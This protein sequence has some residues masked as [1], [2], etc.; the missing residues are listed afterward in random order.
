MRRIGVTQRVVA[1]PGR[2]ERRDALDQ[3]WCD[4]LAACDA[5]AVPIPNRTADAASFVDGL[6]LDGVLLSGGNDVA[7][8]PG[9]SEVAPER[10]ALESELIEL[11]A[12]RALPL[13]GVCHGLQ[14][15]VV[16]YGGRL[17]RVAGHVGEPHGLTERPGVFPVALPERVNSFHDF[18]VLEGDVGESLRVGAV[19]G[20]GLVEAVAHRMRR[21]WGIL[22]HPERGARDERDVRLLKTLFSGGRD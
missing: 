21:Q 22:W 7:E 14:R 13:V 15:L 8:A 18:G 5:V 12:V 10:D 9:G 20:G 6:R 3:S 17:A 4:V 19:A 1:I 11:C 2:D 16:H